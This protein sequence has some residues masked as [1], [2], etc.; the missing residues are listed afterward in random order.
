MTDELRESRLRFAMARCVNYRGVQ[1]DGSG[2]PTYQRSCAAGLDPV[3]TFPKPV[4]RWPC[5][6]NGDR[7]C[8]SK[9]TL[10]R[11]EAER[12]YAEA[13]MRAGYIAATIARAQA[14]MHGPHP[15]GALIP[16]PKCDGRVMV[17]SDRRGR[18]MSGRC[19]TAGC[20]QWMS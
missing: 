14:Q 2:A 1:P 7:A 11:A 10:T 5:F 16:C 12:E 20:L 17:R 4:T 15:M 19:G 9:R 13:S 3:A 6:G 18:V 8:H